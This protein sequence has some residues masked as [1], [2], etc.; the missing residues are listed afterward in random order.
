MMKCGDRRTQ[1]T[2]FISLHD[3]NLEGATHCYTKSVDQLTMGAVKQEKIT[4]SQFDD[5]SATLKVMRDKEQRIYQRDFHPNELEALWRKILIDWMTF[6]VDHCHLQRQ[7]VAAAAFF[8]DI[9]MG[10]GLIE[11]REE[12]QLAAAS[13][14][15]LAL[16]LFDSTV[17]RI[18]KLV[19]LGRGLFTEDDVA[20]MEFKILR[21]LDFHC[22]P[23]STYCFLRQYERLL[24]HSV[25]ESSRRMIDEVTKLV[26]DL[27]VADH[28]YNNYSM[29]VIAYAAMLMAM[30]LMNAEDLPIGQRQC[31]V[32]RMANVSELDSN[33][34]LI[35][36]V[37]EELKA[38]LDSSSKLEDLLES[39]RQVRKESADNSPEK[40]CVKSSSFSDAKL[41]SPRDVMG[42]VGNYP[43][44]NSSASLRVDPSP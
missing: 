6:V 4:E 23:P 15:Q 33:S 8:L 28:N 32:A 9:A 19:S 27:T 3:E 7:A 37:F 40:D 2:G 43:K 11:T 16:K 20:V 26:A 22:H 14:L 29:S 10:K 35:L 25:T 24:P 41:Q 5:V 1:L 44:S 21:T 31:F 18:E 42:R 39:L 13:C 34:P 17:I 30:E 36:E 38:T 12:H